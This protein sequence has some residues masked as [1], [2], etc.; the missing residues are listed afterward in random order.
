MTQEQIPHQPMLIDHVPTH[1]QIVAAKQ[2]EPLDPAHAIPRADLD[3]IMIGAGYSVPDRATLVQST[4]SQTPL[5]RPNRSNGTDPEPNIESE[6]YR[7]QTPEEARKLREQYK[8][9]H[10]DTDMT[11]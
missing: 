10:P 3:T 9:L 4:G 6:L 1:E 5:E 8:A 2:A 11:H 7:T